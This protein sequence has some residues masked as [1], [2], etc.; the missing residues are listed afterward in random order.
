MKYVNTFKRE[1]VVYFGNVYSFDLMYK[2]NDV[3]LLTVTGENWIVRVP[4][5]NKYANPCEK[6][7]IAAFYN[8]LT[9]VICP[10]LEY[11]YFT[12]SHSTFR[13]KGTGVELVLI[14]KHLWQNIK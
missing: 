9:T 13:A 5:L 3:L 4:L 2:K 6:T 12:P 7:R 11:I 14:L 1:S 10:L 8:R